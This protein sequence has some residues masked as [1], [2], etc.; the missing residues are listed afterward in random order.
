MNEDSRRERSGTPALDYGAEREIVLRAQAGDVSAFGEL[1]DAYA[2]RVFRFCNA[3]VSSAADAEDLAEEVFLKAF[4]ALGRFEWRDASRAKSPFAAWLFRI[5]GN[6]VISHYRRGASRPAFE[7]LSES[8]RDERRGPEELAELQMT[9]R[10]VF[11]AVEQLSTAQ[12]EVILLRFSAGLSVAE[13][14]ETLGKQETNVKVLQHKGV[15]RLRQILI[16]EPVQ[17]ERLR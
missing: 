5:A 7:D 16:G 13:T 4:Q 3:R 8:I 15:K 2:V 6:H 14:A 9:V 1:Y 10:E 12:R 17:P 11:A